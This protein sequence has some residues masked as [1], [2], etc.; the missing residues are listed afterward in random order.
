M[1]SRQKKPRNGRVGPDRRART[2]RATAPDRLDSGPPNVTGQAADNR[3][4]IVHRDWLVPARQLCGQ[5]ALQTGR[6]D[7]FDE[8]QATG[9]TDRRYVGPVDMDA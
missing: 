7:R 9:L 1:A 2:R 6:A 8:P 5:G 3:A 4:Q